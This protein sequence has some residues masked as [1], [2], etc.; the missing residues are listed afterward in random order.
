MIAYHYLTDF[1]IEHPSEYTDWILKCLDGFGSAAGPI[2]YIFCSDD[3]LLE[4]NQQHLNHDYY[5]DIIT[6]QYGEG[7]EI[8]GDIYISVDR[9]KENAETFKE[10]F[11]R[12]L[13]RVMIHGILHLLGFRDG[14]E[15]EKRDMRRR[16]DEL[17]EMF[18]VKH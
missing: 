12:E 1:N 14:S 15:Q 17:L 2:E 11:E 10:P 5:T 7:P 3:K 6:F 13:K 8:S 4:I 9:I 16:E 18:H